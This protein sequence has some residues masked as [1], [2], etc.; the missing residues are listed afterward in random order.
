MRTPIAALK[1]LLELLEDGAKDD[2]A[3]RDD[4][5]RT[6]RLE[7]DRLGRLVADLLTL[8][9]LEAG[10]FAL[11]VQPDS[12]ESLLRSV[13][14][15]M[16]ALAERAG[17]SLEV[18]VPEGDLTVMADR[19]RIIQVLL[20]FVD[21][22]LKHSS[23]GESVRLEAFARDDAVR[24]QV[25]DHGPG[26]EPEELPRIFDRFYRADE[27]RSAPRGAGL[28]LAI[29]KEIVEAH[30]SAVVVEQTPGGGATF[31]FDLPPA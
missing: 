31:G 21:N 7:A 24:F 9:Q 28:G 6:M 25:A 14:S 16:H 30:G 26:I 3:V 2:P 29:A 12:A 4:F 15:V 18:I 20:G 5:V 13:A 22:A 19:D 8:A 23:A 1:G 27:A 11:D 10:S 17:V